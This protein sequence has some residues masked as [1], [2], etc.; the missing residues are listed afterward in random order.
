MFCTKWHKCLTR[1]EAR[2]I[3]RFIV[4]PAKVESNAL[5]VG[6]SV[7]PAFTG[8]EQGIDVASRYFKSKTGDAI[9]I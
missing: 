5:N 6:V 8:D 1:N 7:D 9:L 3:S 4:I 2:D